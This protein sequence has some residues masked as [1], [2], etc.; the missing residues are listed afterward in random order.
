VTDNVAFVQKLYDAFGAGDVVTVVGALDPQI[1]WYAAENSPYALPDGKPY[2]GPQA[3]VDG[4]FARIPQDTDG[5]RIEVL[6]LIGFD[7]TVLAENR[8]H[9][10]GKATGTP[11][12]VQVA[13]V[14]YLRDGKV[15]RWQQ[16]VDT[17]GYRQAL[18]LIS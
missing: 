13:H 12:D 7:D 10:T 2:I 15:V 4:V 6:R 11:F 16:H 14:W 9:G 8:Y 3:V 18:G 1:E 17:W 5:F